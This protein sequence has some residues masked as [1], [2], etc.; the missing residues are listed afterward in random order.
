MFHIPIS[1]IKYLCAKYTFFIH[2]GEKRLVTSE[3]TRDPPPPKEGEVAKTQAEDEEGE[4]LEVGEIVTT[5]GDVDVVKEESHFISESAQIL[6]GE[7]MGC[8]HN[9]ENLKQNINDVQKKMKNI[10][11]FF[12]RI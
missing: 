12:W 3:D 10:I 5:T 9:L 6:I 8:S 11:D 7:R 2:I 1:G 4:V